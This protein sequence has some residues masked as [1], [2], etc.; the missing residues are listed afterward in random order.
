MIERICLGPVH[1]FEAYDDLTK[2]QLFPQEE[3]FISGA[4]EKRR[5][6]FATVRRCARAALAELGVRAAPILPGEYGA[7]IWPHGIVGSMTHCAGFRAAAVA[8][9]FTVHSIGIDAEPN[10]VL[11][12]GVLNIVALPTELAVMP[13]GGIVCWDRLL[14]CAKECVYKAW[15]PLARRFL[16]CDEAE[17]SLNASGTFTA[18]LLVP[19]PT[20]GGN[21]L[22][23]FTGRWT[24][25]DGLLAAA[26]IVPV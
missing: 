7:P 23:G 26:I 13:T 1:A 17:V 25:S 11:P 14:F 10:E 24:Y 21:P 16:D 20:I 5:T 6:E 9:A 15:F 8:R 4:V 19:G 3:E 18:R 2:V 12:K 22:R